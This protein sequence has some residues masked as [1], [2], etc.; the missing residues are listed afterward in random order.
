MCFLQALF[1]ARQT[2]HLRILPVPTNPC[3]LLMVARCVVLGLLLMGTGST[4]ASGQQQDT[5]AV[6]TATT[7]TASVEDTTSA[8]TS[9][10]PAET[11]IV[12]RIEGAFTDGDAARLLGLAADRVE[13]SL[14]G[15]Q[16]FY[17][18]SQAFYV[19]QGFF[20]DYSP[21]RFAIGDVTRTGASYFV[22][23]E[24]NHGRSAQT[25]QVYVRLVRRD[26]EDA[27][28]LREIRIEEAAE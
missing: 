11:E 15:T 13:V 5:T 1:A 24:Y 6:D 9:P 21:R 20:E 16:T 19:L 3:R 18:S 2:I 4:G 14:F 22:S 26:G 25:L 23:G 27:W 28:G 12:D 10:P 8:G 7:D 17:S